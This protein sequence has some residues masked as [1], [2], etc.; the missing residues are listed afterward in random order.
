MKK[1]Y[2]SLIAV[3]LFL[4]VSATSIILISVGIRLKYEE[5]TRQKMELEVQLKSE[6][7]LRIKLLADQQ[8]YTDENLIENFA[9]ENLGM[10]KMNYNALRL[11]I[12]QNEL[13]EINDELKKKYE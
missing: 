3:L 13:D 5:L 1:S 10:I 2:K 12:N 8:M 9:K 6:N 7:T 4:L 11:K